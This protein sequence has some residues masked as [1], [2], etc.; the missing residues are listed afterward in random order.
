[1]ECRAVIVLLFAP[2][3]ALAGD[4][5]DKPVL[6]TEWHGQ[7]A[8]KLRVFPAAGAPQSAP[9]E[10]HIRPL[11]SGHYTWTIIYGDGEKRQIRKYELKP[12]DKGPTHFVIDEKNGSLIDL[13]MLD[14]SLRGMFGVKNEKGGRDTLIVTTYRLAGE[15]LVV[16]MTSFPSASPRATEIKAAGMSVESY[17][18]ASLQVA[19]LTRITE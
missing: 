8:G 13:R 16:E 6:P 3:L 12:G 10:L 17:L 5:K 11:D 18:P 15:K 19:E 4:V 1:M 7:W 14:G 9:M 2:A